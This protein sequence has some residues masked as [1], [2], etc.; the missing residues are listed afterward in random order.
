MDFILKADYVLTVSW[1]CA[2]CTGIKGVDG[3]ERLIK[4]DR[5]I[6]RYEKFIAHTSLLTDIKMKK[7]N[8]LYVHTYIVINK[9]NGGNGFSET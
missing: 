7:L 3:T 5:C 2:C 6:F 9:G 1:R 8:K 4:I